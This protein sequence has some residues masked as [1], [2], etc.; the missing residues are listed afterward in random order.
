VTRQESD[1]DSLLAAWRRFLR[2]RRQH[3]A[4]IAGALRP[5]DLPEPLIGFERTQGEERIVCLFNL[6][7]AEARTPLA[8]VAPLAGH[9]FAARIE[10]DELVLPPHGVFFGEPAAAGLRARIRELER[11]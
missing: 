11:V 2:W 5:L 3:P 4:L 1:P 8:G 6:S 9:G 10:S 7:D